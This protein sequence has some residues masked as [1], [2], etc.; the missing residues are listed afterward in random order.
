MGS[1]DL[2]VLHVFWRGLP[3]AFCAAQARLLAGALDGG[4][5]V[6]GA[7]GDV[8]SLASVV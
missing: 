5:L 2:E 8:V 3:A 7:G 4:D 1:S 6:M